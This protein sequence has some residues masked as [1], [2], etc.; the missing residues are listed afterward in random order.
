MISPLYDSMSAIVN[1]IPLYFK[2]R[3]IISQLSCI[4]M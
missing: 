2:G 4:I 1:S 3:D